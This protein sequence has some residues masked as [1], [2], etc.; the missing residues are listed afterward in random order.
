MQGVQGPPRL[1]SVIGAPFFAPIFFLRQL[2]ARSFGRRGHPAFEFS[3]KPSAPERAPRDDPQPFPHAQ[4]NQFPFGAAAQ[5]IVL[6][7]QTDKSFPSVLPARIDRPLQLPT[8]EV[9]CSHITNHALPDQV[10]QRR[11]RFFQRRLFI[12][13]MYLVEIDVICLQASEAGFDRTQNMFST[14]TEIVWSARPSE[15]ELSSR[16]PDHLV[17]VYFSQRPT[18]SSEM[19]VE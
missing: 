15:T 11:Q 13:A 16:S 4:R 10:V 7:L 2:D 17:A 9:A 3:G 18:I 8:A 12:P 19:P 14:Q 5:E 6:G 1:L